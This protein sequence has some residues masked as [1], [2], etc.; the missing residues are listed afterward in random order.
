[1][2]PGNAE[3]GARVF[4]DKKCSGCHAINGQGGSL[5][6]DL[7]NNP[8]GRFTPANLARE[9]WNHGPQMWAMMQAT[10]AKKPT[11]SHQDAADLFA[12]LYGFRYFEDPGDASRGRKVFDAKGC[13]G[14]HARGTGGAL[15]A[16]NWQ[17]V[18]D[19]VQLARAMW[20]HAPPMKSAMKE[21]TSWP[22]LTAQDLTDLLAYVRGT[23]EFGKAPTK[24][25]VASA[26]TGATLFAEKGC[27]SCHSG[28]QALG[29]KAG[30][31]TLTE[32]AVAMWNHAPKMRGQA[33]ELRPE[34]MTRLV[35]YLWSIQYFDGAGDPA[36]GLEIAA[37]K[38][39]ISCHGD[40][41]GGTPRFSSYSGKMDAIRFIS[42]SW[43]HAAGMRNAMRNAA[44]DWPQLDR[45]N[46]IDVLAYINSL[47]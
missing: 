35:G 10:G 21:N 6:P 25:A 20:N 44:K 39:C 4:R 3:R 45:G 22:V 40:P 29:G 43:N 47:R 17:T 38:G 26:E 19:P 33:A 41:Q 23:P 18:N 24:L 34:E 46:V 28:A 12:Y 37:T 1:M 2:I 36:K 14:C 31:R 16:M 32:L 5:A 9:I 27:A 15:P 42:G 11:L 7:A 13:I 8:P 30:T